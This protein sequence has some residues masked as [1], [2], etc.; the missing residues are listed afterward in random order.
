MQ[1]IFPTS[2][3]RVD[4]RPPGRRRG[5]C[6]GASA[7]C[8]RTPRSTTTSSAEEL[9]AY[10]ARALRLSRRRTRARVARAARRS[11]PRRRAPDAA[12]QVLEGHDPARRPRPGAHQ[13]SGSRVPRRADVG[14]RSDRPPRRP[15]HHPASPRSRRDRVLQLAH[16]GD[17]E[18]MCSR[19]GIVAGGKL[20]AAGTLAEMVP[21]RFADGISCWQASSADARGGA[22]GARRDGDRD[23]RRP[24]SRRPA[25]D[26]FVR[27]GDRAGDVRRRRA[28]VDEP[29]SRHARGLFPRARAA[30]PAA[31]SFD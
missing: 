5:R 26:G 9:L 6:A 28:G 15:R 19:V 13:R 20:V 2:A 3:A 24:L 30:E 8:R 18:T 27:R 21:F 12:A 11:R 10:F 25:V 14:A 7:T 16:P 22:G 23:R 1:L 4:S 31:R 29:G 17:A